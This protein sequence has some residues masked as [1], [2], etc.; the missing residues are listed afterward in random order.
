MFKQTHAILKLRKGFVMPKLYPSLEAIAF[1][2]NSSL[3]KGLVDLF[4]DIIDY[5]NKINTSIQD[6][7]KE[8]IAYTKKILYPRFSKLVKETTGLNCKKIV[9][10]KG[11]TYGFAC[12]MDV[13]DRYG[14]NARVFID[15]YSGTGMDSYYK[16]VLKQ[17]N[18]R[19]TT[20][21]DIQNL[22]NSLRKDTGIYAIDQ[23][24][25][26]RKVSFTL[27]FD[28][29]ASFLIQEVG[30]NKCQ[31]FTAEEIAAIVMHEIGHLHS[32]LE[33]ALDG[34][35][36]MGVVMTAYEYFNQHATIEEK[37][38]LV[39]V[40]SKVDKTPDAVDKVD[41]L[42]N[43][44]KDSVGDYI[45]DGFGILIS[46]II[47]A[48]MIVAIPFTVINQLFSYMDDASTLVALNT[49][50]T[51]LS[52][53]AISVHNFKL[54]ERLAD[55][56]VVRHGLG[57]ALVS[58]LNKLDYNI[59]SGAGTSIYAKNSSIAWNVAKISYFI[60]VLL[61]G[62]VYHFEEHDAMPVR[63]ELIM[64]ETIKVFKQNLPPDMLDYYIA[65]YESSQQALENRA[66][67]LRIVE[68]IESFS[69]LLRYLVETPA[70]LILSGRFP[71]EYEQLIYKTKQ[72]VDNKLY[73]RAAK[74]TQLL[75]L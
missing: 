47:N 66:T 11:I 18:L 48:A 57:R 40:L 5:R 72:L 14:L 17:Y 41:D 61:N 70:G 26:G 52:D 29:F 50:S 23:L 12:T 38:K 24:Y 65:D 69:K 2:R 55:Q 1:Q 32:M 42:L 30:H 4:Q 28:P 60:T 25:D 46:A 39:S 33:H 43:E 13:G 19:C 53:Q 59:A 37:A 22:V 6:R 8:T 49:S 31:P 35:M 44:R 62:D 68:G 9:F 15:S 51:K 21:K 58:S 36:R 54:C 74:L 27:Y 67:T 64:Q 20:V 10:S 3:A 73:F 56:F 16:W 75:N 7:V 45:L 34:C 71:R 63:G